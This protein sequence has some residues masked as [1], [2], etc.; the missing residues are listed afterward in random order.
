MNE[1]LMFFAFSLYLACNLVVLVGWF[2][3]KLSKDDETAQIYSSLAKLD[4]SLTALIVIYNLK[5]GN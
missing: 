4:V 3:M 2:I 5:W 1:L